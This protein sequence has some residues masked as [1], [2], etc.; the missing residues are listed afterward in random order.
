MGFDAAALCSLSCGVAQGAQPTFAAHQVVVLDRELVSIRLPVFKDP[1][2]KGLLGFKLWFTSFH[3]QALGKLA[4]LFFGIAELLD[5]HVLVNPALALC[6]FKPTS[7]WCPLMPFFLSC[8]INLQEESLLLVSG[9]LAPVLAGGLLFMDEVIWCIKEILGPLHCQ[10]GHS[11]VFPVLL[12]KFSFLAQ[13]PSGNS[14]FHGSL[15]G[16]LVS[17]SQGRSCGWHDP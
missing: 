3:W 16:V 17:S 10:R 14:H 1:F 8:D 9:L 6:A 5:G 2:N 13:W 12:A 11:V 15:V 4:L 7:F